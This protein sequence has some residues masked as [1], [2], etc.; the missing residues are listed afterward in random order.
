GQQFKY[1]GYVVNFLA[2]NAKIFRKLLQ[3]PK[4]L[5]IMLLRLVQK[6]GSGDD[7]TR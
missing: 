5:D 7:R 4:N 3:L 6:E 2:K 1:R